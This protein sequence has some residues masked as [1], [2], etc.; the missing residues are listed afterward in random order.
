MLSIG[1]L[2]VPPATTSV[3]NVANNLA[4]SATTK[5]RNENGDKNDGSSLKRTSADDVSRYKNNSGGTSSSMKQSKE[6]S[7][8]QHIKKPLNAF[9]LYMKEMRPK[10]MQEAG[11]KERQSA[12]INRILGRRVRKKIIPET[13][14][15]I[16]YFKAFVT[17]KGAPI[18]HLVE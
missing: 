17:A 6:M 11:L 2:V 12:E 15:G 8:K 5:H 14:E 16:I 7:K 1:R 13:P 9:M 18:L 3:T 4:A 10:V